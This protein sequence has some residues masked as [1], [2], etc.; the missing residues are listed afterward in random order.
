MKKKIGLASIPL[1]VLMLACTCNLPFLT[2]DDTPPPLFQ[3]TEAP[4]E[5]TSP[6][7]FAQDVLFKDD[8][9]STLSGWEV[10]EY[11][12]GSVGYEMGRY[13]VI[14][15][16]EGETMWGV[17]NQSFSDL[18][19]EVETQQVQAGPGNDNDYGVGCRL[20]PNGDGYYLLISGDG[21]YA[22]FVAT[23]DGFAPLVDFTASDVI[24]TGNADNHIK[25]VCDGPHLELFVNGRHLAS[26]EDDT[27]TSGDIALTATS[28]EEA[29]TEIHFDDL[30]VYRP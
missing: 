9:S 26:S 8:F 16:G 5:A 13:F 24:R 17:A 4:R 19:I 12:T 2:G 3:E 14:A 18:I 22:I 10:G 1:M 15:I 20:Q 25:A 30:V 28:Y 6:P 7:T 11:E 23:E 21:Y 29:R 27:F